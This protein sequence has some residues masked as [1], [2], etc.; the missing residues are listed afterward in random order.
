MTTFDPQSDLTRPRGLR[1][2]MVTA[3]LVVRVEVGMALCRIG[4]H[5]MVPHGLRFPL[6]VLAEF[7]D[8]PYQQSRDGTWWRGCWCGAHMQ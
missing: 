8:A 5:R 6:E 7:P 1:D 3:G 2:L 4:V